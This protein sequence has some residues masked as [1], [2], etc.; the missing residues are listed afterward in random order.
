[1]ALAR[2]PGMP[3]EA[4]YDAACVFGVV[5]ENTQDPAAREKHAVRCVEVLRL[6]HAAGFGKDFA[7]RLTSKSGSFVQQMEHDPD[8][9]SVRGR[10]DYKRLLADLT[11]KP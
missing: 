10:A 3:G 7:Q 5:A 1:D 4:L 2:L 8:L 11:R 9:A 6:A